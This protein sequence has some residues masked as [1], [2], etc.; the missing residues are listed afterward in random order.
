MVCC[1]A[2]GIRCD[3]AEFRIPSENDQT[4]FNVNQDRE[5]SANPD[6]L[7]S[8]HKIRKCDESGGIQHHESKRGIRDFGQGTAFYLGNRKHA[9]SIKPQLQE[10]RDAIDRLRQESRR[11]QSRDEGEG[12]EEPQQF[13]TYE[14]KAER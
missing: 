8:N 7:L 2:K 12:S 10:K 3:R 5:A 6:G 4:L 11:Q 9:K 13:V 1:Y 14:F